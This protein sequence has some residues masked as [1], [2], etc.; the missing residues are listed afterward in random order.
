MDEQLSTSAWWLPAL[1]FRPRVTRLM[2]P[3]RRDSRWSSE[4]A[5]HE[6]HRRRGELIEQ[7][8]RHSEARGI[9]DV[10]REEIVDDAITAVVMSPRGIANENHLIGA[11]WLAAAHRCRRHREGRHLTRLGSQR[12]IEFEI[13]TRHAPDEANPYDALERS[14]RFARASDLVAELDAIE[15]Q[16]FAVMA[17]RGIGAVSAARVLGIPLGEARSAARSANAKL[18]RVAVIYAAGR[19]CEFRASA[20]VADAAGQASEREATLARAHVSA[21]V[22]CRKVYRRL[23]REMRSR[24]F[25]RAAAAAFIPVAPVST[26]HIG[27]LGKLAIWIE[28]RMGF[29]PRG[30]GERA[31]E[32]L[33]G[34]GIAKAA[35]AGT[36]IVA[37]GGAL[38]GHIFQ[39]IQHPP[40]SAAHHRPHAARRQPE[41]TVSLA[42]AT[43]SVTTR[44]SVSATAQSSPHS[45]AHTLPRPP[46]RSLAY[47]A[48]GAPASGT[49]SSPSSE[50]SSQKPTARAASAGSSPTPYEGAASERA[51]T[52][53]NPPAPTQSGGG[54]GLGYLG[55]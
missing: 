43:T 48:V 11:F 37:A 47:L 39:A 26:T 24:E 8:R 7:L 30:S 16:V 1:R 46:S 34:A 17:S 54:S 35:V 3:R 6:L 18:D 14:D 44:P 40:S 21:C 42:S 2:R 29:M 12:R 45:S 53:R 19:M 36:A 50:A 28:Q 49:G 33:G 52:P 13:A 10:A 32:V 22:A 31:G 38:T 9:P 23:R 15:R 25:Q 27:G 55:P 51:P 5:A 4:E 41:A 20:L